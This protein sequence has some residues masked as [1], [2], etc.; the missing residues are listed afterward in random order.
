MCG[1]IFDRGTSHTFTQKDTHT[2]TVVMQW[3]T[4]PKEVVMNRGNTMIVFTSC[5]I[6]WL[7]QPLWVSCGKKKK[8]IIHEN[9]KPWF[10]FTIQNRYSVRCFCPS[11]PRSNNL[12]FPH[13]VVCLDE[14]RPFLCG[15]PS[16]SCCRV[17]DEYKCCYRD[18]KGAKLESQKASV[19]SWKRRHRLY[20]PSR[21]R[22]VIDDFHWWFGACSGHNGKPTYHTASFA[23]TTSSSIQKCRD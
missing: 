9:G 23:T 3:S 8:I 5:Y 20:F 2:H 21:S 14:I 18:N 13:P 15:Q 22:H 16:S 17:N 6:S 4:L 11:S 12:H 1:C 19:I 10:I 7:E